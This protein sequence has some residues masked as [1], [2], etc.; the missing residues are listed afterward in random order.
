MRFPPAEP[1]L[2]GK[3]CRY[4]AG[5]I[6]TGYVSSIAVFADRLL[7]A[8]IGCTQA[9]RLD[10]LRSTRRATAGP[11]DV[12]LPAGADTARGAR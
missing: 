8:V 12:L 11:T 4:L 5:C 2:D 3:E 6:G 10:E 9:R 1:L 7:A